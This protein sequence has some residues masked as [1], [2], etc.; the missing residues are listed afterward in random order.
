MKSKVLILFFIGIFLLLLLFFLFFPN[1]PLNL[2][3]LR[4]NTD[5]EGKT[6]I[7]V[8]DK[9]VEIFGK[10]IEKG[11]LA[12][13]LYFSSLFIYF[14][15]VLYVAFKQEKI[16]RGPSIQSVVKSKIARAI[17][18]NRFHKYGIIR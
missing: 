7:N 13:Y 2:S 16:S 18:H 10:K 12:L 4:F 14:I 15:F 6:L 11:L 5:E 9:E 1:N 17:Q 3:N 8:G